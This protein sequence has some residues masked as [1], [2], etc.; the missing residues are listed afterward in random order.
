MSDLETIASLEA[1]LVRW[2]DENCDDIDVGWW[3]NNTAQ[4]MA[5]ALAQMLW[6]QR[7]SSEIAERKG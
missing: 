6:M 3:G 7:E 2:M 5:I 4:Y 1:M